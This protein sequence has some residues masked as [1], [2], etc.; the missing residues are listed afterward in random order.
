MNTSHAYFYSIVDLVPKVKRKKEFAI[1]VVQLMIVIV[2]LASKFHVI[3]DREI[4]EL[5]MKIKTFKG[6]HL[7]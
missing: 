5:E 6:L 7:K 2:I 1:I 3:L 4:Q